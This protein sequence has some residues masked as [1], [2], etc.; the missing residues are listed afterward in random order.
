[1]PGFGSVGYPR[2]ETFFGH[3]ILKAIDN[4]AMT[5]VQANQVAQQW[6]NSVSDFAAPL[7]G[8]CTQKA[9]TRC[10]GRTT[11]T[12]CPTVTLTATFSFGN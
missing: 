4:C 8:R 7:L 3:N 1:M 12:P 2:T 10:P 9:S 6:L 5:E 11:P